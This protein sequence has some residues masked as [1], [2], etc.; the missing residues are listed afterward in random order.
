[1]VERWGDGGNG[2]ILE[3]LGT[4]QLGTRLPVRAGVALER[5]TFRPGD[6]IAGPTPES[7]LLWL[8]S[9]TLTVVAGPG[10]NAPVLVT[11]TDDVATGSVVSFGNTG[12]S[13]AVVVLVVIAPLA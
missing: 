1:M 6:A 5:V 10:S 13:P 2:V 11:R 4:A 7:R 12:A 9:G 8:E 3:T